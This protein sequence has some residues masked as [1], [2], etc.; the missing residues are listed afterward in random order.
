MAR[1]STI[2]ASDAD[3]ESVVDRLRNAAAEGRLAAHELEHRVTAAL[4]AKTYG[5]L[6]ATVADLPAERE[7]RQRRAG[8][9]R[10]V[11][12]VRE[13]PVLVVM[14]LPILIAV[15]A[16]VLAVMIVLTMAWA[17][18]ML[19]VLLVTHDRRTY[20]GRGPARPWMYYRDPRRLRNSRTDAVSGFIPWL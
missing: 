8:A 1:R 6:D 13:H 20:R 17:F 18:V 19:I 5:E 7:R 15:V 16:V 12:T 10:A 2:R 4:T 3:R 9:G 11:S 14:A